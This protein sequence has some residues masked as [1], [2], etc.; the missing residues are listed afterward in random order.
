MND[1]E[2]GRLSIIEDYRKLIADIDN[3]VYERR[4]PKFDYKELYSDYKLSKMKADYN[5]L[6]RM[7]ADIRN[8]ETVVSAESNT[9][10]NTDNKYSNET[11]RMIKHLLSKGW[12]VDEICY[13]TEKIY[14]AGRI[15]KPYD[16]KFNSNYILALFL[17]YSLLG[18]TFGALWKMKRSLFKLIK[19]H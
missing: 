14:G 4:T 15:S 17:N 7:I 5:T 12:S 18:L 3:Y 1:I 2:R 11:K 9:L 8:N 6:I 19:K 16:L 10:F 13:E